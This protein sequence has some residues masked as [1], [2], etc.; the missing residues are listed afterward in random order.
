VLFLS[1]SLANQVRADKKGVSRLRF[2]ILSI[3][4]ILALAASHCS[5]ASAAQNVG[6]FQIMLNGKP[7]SEK[8]LTR[9]GFVY[10]PLEAM[11]RATGVTSECNLKEKKISF[12]GKP[13]KGKAQ[14][15]PEGLVYVS[16]SSLVENLGARIKIDSQKGVVSIFT[17][18]IAVK[19]TPVTATPTQTAVPTIPEPFI[20]INATN[21][22]F[23]VQVTNIETVNSMKG[24]YTPKAGNKFVVVYLSQSN[25]SDEV[26]IYTGK[27]A[28]VDSGGQA[29][30]HIEALSNFWLLVLRPGGNNFGYLVFEIPVTATPMQV[31][32]STTTRP[33]LSINLR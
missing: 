14:K 7:L 15:T 3:L 18:S 12:N 19:T 2:G 4:L 11:A 32:L 17:G 30:E 26:Q 9:D 25:I 8:A 31:V 24:H 28:L 13:V 16:A 27:F 29:Y 33:P 22:V 5:G 20:P 21:D 23:K 6:Y 1:T 10:L